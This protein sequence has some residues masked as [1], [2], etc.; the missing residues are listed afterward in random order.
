MDR[1]KHVR[2][3]PSL[4]MQIVCHTGRYKD[5]EIKHYICFTSKHGHLINELSDITKLAM[6]V[7]GNAVALHAEG[8][9][10]I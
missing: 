3:C 5:S 1:F 10:S 9:Y 6:S 8:R 7:K 4:H 2:M